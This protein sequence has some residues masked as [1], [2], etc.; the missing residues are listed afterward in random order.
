MTERAGNI[1]NKSVREVSLPP[2]VKISIGIADSPEFHSTRIAIVVFN[3][4][5][6]LWLVSFGRTFVGQPMS[7]ADGGTTAAVVSC[8]KDESTINAR[9]SLVTGGFVVLGASHVFLSSSV[10]SIASNSTVMMAMLFTS[11]A[12]RLVISALL[13]LRFEGTPSEFLQVVVYNGRGMLMYLLP[14]VCYVVNDFCALI[15]FVLLSPAE[16]QVLIQLRI[17]VIAFVWQSAMR[18]NLSSRRWIMLLVCVWAVLLKERNVVLRSFLLSTSGFASFRRFLPM[19][20]Q[21]TVS[22]IA[23]IANERLLKSGVADLHAQNVILNVECSVFV[24]AIFG[25][26]AVFG[27]PTADFNRQ[28]QGHEILTREVLVASMPMLMLCISISSVMGIASSYL[29]KRY[30]NIE[31]ELAGMAVT[32]VVAAGEWFVLRTSTCG[33]I[34]VESVALLLTA[35]AIYIH[36]DGPKA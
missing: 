21:L 20:I 18:R 14:T 34:D 9:D 33:I 19:A 3:V 5:L 27:S 7:A 32:V 25:V 13:Y 16:Y 1:V 12:M 31:K 23:S 30:G 11:H 26:M 24:G 35:L 22:T 15:S 17:I 28:P 6:L 8:K 2:P 4:L 36:L 29:L 10:A